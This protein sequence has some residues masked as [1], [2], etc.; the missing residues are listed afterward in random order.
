MTPV[1]YSAFLPHVLP[2]VPHCFEE[3]AIIAI[4]NACIDFCRDTL[5]LQQDIDPIST[6]AQ[7][8]TYTIDSVDSG[9][10][11]TQVMS[12]YYVGR[13]L[14]RKSEY[15]LQRLYTMDWQQLEGTPKVWT[16]FNLSDVTVALKPAESVTG[17]LTGRV[18]YM[19]TR[20]STTVD[21]VL[22][23]VYLDDIVDGALARLKST[24]DQPYSDVQGAMVHQQKFKAGCA[25]ARSLVNGGMNHAPMRVR[26]NRIW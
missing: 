26:F 11:V 17:A 4:R 16:Q 12:L 5:V 9:Y 23:E 24:P 2:Y 19:P 7:Q 25:E 8:N 21:G 1:S 14:E 18:A 22:Y 6:V 10:T 3:Q 20:A 15:E 13:R